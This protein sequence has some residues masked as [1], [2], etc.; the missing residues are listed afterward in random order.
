VTLNFTNAGGGSFI[1][2]SSIH[3]HDVYL[4]VAVQELP[5]CWHYLYGE[6]LDRIELGVKR[7]VYKFFTISFSDWRQNVALG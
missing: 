4:Y 5:E 3:I 1:G 2:T 6:R 7:G